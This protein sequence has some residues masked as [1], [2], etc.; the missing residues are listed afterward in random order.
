MTTNPTKSKQLGLLTLFSRIGLGTV[1][2]G[3]DYGI[4][5][6][7]G[8]IPQ[9]GAFDILKR[10]RACGIHLLDTASSYGDSEVVIGEFI[11]KGPFPFRVVSKFSLDPYKEGKLGQVLRQSLA[12]MNVSGVYGYLAHRLTDVLNDERLWLDMLEVKRKN[13][14]QKIGFSIYSP[15]ELEELDKRNI[16]FDLIQFPYSIF[17][18]RFEKCMHGLKQQN[19]EIHA[20][21]IF[22]Q[23]LVFMKADQLPGHLNKAVAPLSRLSDLSLKHGISIQSLCLNFALLNPH[24]D[25]VIMGVDG[26]AHFEEN[27]KSLE[28]FEKVR[29]IYDQLQ[30]L[31]IG[32]EDILLPNRWPL[33]MASKR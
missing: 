8:K 23:G 5:N 18:R 31:S 17:D 30:E 19:I 20:R 10:A 7:G 32:N 25:R 12:R 28:D 13:F 3:Q 33:G 24:I 1:Q 14:V 9:D 2:F 26:L 15:H 22:L 16:K 6:K 11:K 27:L 21:S 29:C 4:A